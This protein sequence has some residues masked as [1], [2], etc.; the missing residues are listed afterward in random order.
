MPNRERLRV[1][2]THAHPTR[3]HPTFAHRGGESDAAGWV[4]VAFC[5]AGFATTV[6]F[7]FLSSAIG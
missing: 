2:S 1:P 3:A 4:V 5:L 7:V 6:F